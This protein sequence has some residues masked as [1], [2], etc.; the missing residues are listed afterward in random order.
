MTADP[1][2][3]PSAE[4]EHGMTGGFKVSYKDAQCYSQVECRCGAYF[5]AVDTDTVA[6]NEKAR[7]KVAAHVAERWG[8]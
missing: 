6:A 4:P 1:W 8:K 3:T 7:Q 5:A 2:D